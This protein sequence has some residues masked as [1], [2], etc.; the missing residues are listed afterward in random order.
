MSWAPVSKCPVESQIQQVL[1]RIIL[2]PSHYTCQSTHVLLVN[3]TTLHLGDQVQKL[4]VILDPSPS[5]HPQSLRGACP[6][7]SLRISS[8]WPH[9]SSLLLPELSSQLLSAPAC[10]IP[11][12]QQQ[13]PC[14]I[15]PL[16]VCQERPC[17]TV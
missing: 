16:P 4:S 3:G 13:P 17:G 9:A 11:M 6:S 14:I 1:D 12:A 8:L 7:H 10:I 5:S 15:S 2:F